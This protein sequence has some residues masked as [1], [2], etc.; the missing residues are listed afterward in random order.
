MIKIVHAADLYRRPVL[1]ASMF[2]DRAAQFSERLRWGAIQLDDLGLE[3]D[4]YDDLNPVYVII[5]DEAGEHCA[6]VRLMP[7]TGRTMLN[8]HFTEL[9][10]GVELR[11]PLI[12]EATRLCLSPREGVPGSVARRAPSALFYA[13]CDLAI[14]SGVEFLVAVYFT[15]MQRVWKLA[16]FAPEVLGTAMTADGEI[17]A[18][19]WEL[20][21]EFRELMGRR[22]GVSG[23]CDLQ[24]FPSEDRFPTLSRTTS[25]ASASTPSPELFQVA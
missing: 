12:W 15:H 4:E 24:Y 21:P 1:A 6:S 13:T 19:L 18:G 17:C 8:E 22:A 9:C 2:R 7:T 10:G 5:E 16:G 3:F 25:G 11:S 23:R 14:R 20:T